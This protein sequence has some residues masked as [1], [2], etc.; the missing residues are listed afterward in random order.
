L[1]KI[2]RSTARWRQPQ[3]S[4]I[5]HENPARSFGLTV[6]PA[7]GQHPLADLQ[8]VLLDLRVRRLVHESQPL[9]AGLLSLDSR[10]HGLT[11]RDGRHVRPHVPVRVEGDV[12]DVAEA[13]LLADEDQA[14]RG[15][16]VARAMAYMMR[17]DPDG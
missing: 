1:Q 6:P 3:T 12:A 8:Q 7:L 15:D 9:L 14:E 17:R 10:L 5:A 4:Q 16:D 11:V 2:R 13:R